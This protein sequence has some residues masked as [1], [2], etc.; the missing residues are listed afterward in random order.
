M[1][2][3][4]N[5]ERSSGAR[6]PVVA[7]GHAT[8]F[9]DRASIAAAATTCIHIDFTSLGLLHLQHCRCASAPPLFFVHRPRSLRAR[10]A[11]T[12]YDPCTGRGYHHVSPAAE[13]LRR[14]HHHL[15][16]LRRCAGGVRFTLRLRPP[17]LPRLPCPP[18]ACPRPARPRLG[19]QHALL[20]EHVRAAQRRRLAGPPR[21]STFCGTHLI[22]I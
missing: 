5:D 2:K 14:H 15:R 16:N 4:K 3:I 6:R 21:P 10:I 1:P 13:K 20:P 11:A 12:V 18:P 9:T 22:F 7:V 17:P 8:A 19:R